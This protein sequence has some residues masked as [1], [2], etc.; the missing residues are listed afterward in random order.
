MNAPPTSPAFK[1]NAHRAL[2]DAQLQK[3]LGNVRA[4]FIDKPFQRAELLAR[5]EALLRRRPP[6]E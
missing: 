5:V 3:A 4:G 6:S 2:G 1:Q